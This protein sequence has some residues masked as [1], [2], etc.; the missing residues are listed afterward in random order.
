LGLAL[1][2]FAFSRV[3]WL[4]AFVPAILRWGRPFYNK[5]W[6]HQHS[7]PRSSINDDPNLAFEDSPTRAPAPQVDAD[8]ASHFDVY[9][10]IASSA[11]WTLGIIFMGLASSQAAAMWGAFFCFLSNVIDTHLTNKTIVDL[12]LA[13]SPH[14]PIAGYWI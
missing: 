3:I 6:S 11:L 8:M 9:L 4:A 10:A 5:R 12:L 7:L 14:P 13:C 2:A 1:S